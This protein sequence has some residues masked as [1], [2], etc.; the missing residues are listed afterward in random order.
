MKRCTYRF[1][2]TGL[3]SGA[4]TTA[5]FYYRLDHPGHLIA[6]LGM[7]GVLIALAGAFR[8]PSSA[9]YAGAFVVVVAASWLGER[10]V[11]GPHVD[12]SDV[13]FTSIGAALAVAALCGRDVGR[14][15]ALVLGVASA[16]F[17][18]LGLTLR[19]RFQYPV[20]EWWWSG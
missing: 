8:S 13:L 15:D 14:R 16:A 6:G 20:S 3:V 11:F 9:S 12:A 2:A 4:I 7:V 18:V 1:V 10:T 17:V 5:V 19:Y